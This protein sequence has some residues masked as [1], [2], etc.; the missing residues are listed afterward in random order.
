MLG[1]RTSL[2]LAGLACACFV[3]ASQQASARD[4]D[5]D[6]AIAG[7]IIGL[8]IGAAV[9]SNH[10]HHHGVYHPGY[11][12][13]YQPGGYNAYY[14]HTYSPDRGIIAH[15]PQRA[16]YHVDS[17]YGVKYSPK[18]SGDLGHNAEA[19]SAPEYG[20]VN[21]H[22]HVDTGVVPRGGRCQAA[23]RRMGRRPP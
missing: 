6:A 15:P 1:R 16:G 20:R 8:A 10:S 9:S 5:V 2:A 18:N 22:P 12:A 3:I 19:H 21:R 14:R 4:K 7:G 17:S 11:V 13:P 23:S